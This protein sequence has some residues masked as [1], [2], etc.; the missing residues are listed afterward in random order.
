M[1][2]VPRQK[3]ALF[4]TCQILEGWI[5]RRPSDN[6]VWVRSCGI[7]LLSRGVNPLLEPQSLK[8]NLPGTVYKWRMWPE[9]KSK[10]TTSVTYFL[11]H[12][13]FQPCKGLSI[14]SYASRSTQSGWHMTGKRCGL[15]SPN[16]NPKYQR[17][18]SGGPQLSLHTQRERERVCVLS[19]P[20]SA[21]EWQVVCIW[22]GL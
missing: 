1:C 14:L 18:R 12:I 21:L 2:W 4:S 8:G 22:F 6:F 5:L 15:R 11:P 10:W 17:T 9:A 19:F 13:T 3:K 16:H 7:T 20:T